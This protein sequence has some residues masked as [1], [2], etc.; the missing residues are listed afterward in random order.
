MFA[1][2]SRF[3]FRTTGTTDVL[4]ITGSTGAYGNSVVTIDALNQS[5]QNGLTINNIGAGDHGLTLNRAGGAGSLTINKFDATPTIYTVNKNLK[6]WTNNNAF[7][8]SGISFLFTD[9]NKTS[10][11]HKTILVQSSTNTLKS[12]SHFEIQKSGSVPILYLAGDVQS[13]S[14]SPNELYISGS[15][16]VNSGNSVITG[17][18]TVVSGNARELQVTSAGV[19]MGNI[20][21]D[22]HTVTGS[23]NISGSTTATS[24]TGSLQGTASYATTASYSETSKLTNNVYFAQGIL[25]DDQVIPAGTDEIIQ[26]TDQFDSQGWWDSGTYQFLPTIEGYYKISLGVWFE[27]PNDNTNQLNAQIRSNGSNQEMLV[28]QPTTTISGVSLFGSKIIYFNGSSDYIDF[29]VYQ[30]TTNNIKI[31]KGSNAGS[32]TWFSAEFM[33]M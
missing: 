30:G 12:G 17:S 32:G 31:L 19:N 3:T 22:I 9:N 16:R 13:G 24:F 7:D 15:L 14:F 4:T 20:I 33:T 5:N 10:T 23:L 25:N 18:L 1:T 6:F 26:F 11:H 8:S 29:T 2:G 27:N 28:Q 21:T